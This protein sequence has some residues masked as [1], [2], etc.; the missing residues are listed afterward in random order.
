MGRPVF[1]RKMLS[2]IRSENGFTLMEVAAVV[3]ILGIIVAGVIAVIQP[4]S[5]AASLKT[6]KAN[7]SRAVDALAGYVHQY[8][9]LPCPADPDRNGATEPYGAERGSGAAGNSFGSC[10]GAAVEGIL[11]FRTLGLTEAEAKDGWG[12]FLTYRVS[13]AFTTS[14]NTGRAH[15][16]CRREAVWFDISGALVIGGGGGDV[17]FSNTGNINISL[18]GG[19]VSLRNRNAQ[20]ARFC[21]PDTAPFA[22]AT[23]IQILD[24]AGGT[25]LWP[26]VRSTSDYDDVN[27]V[28]EDPVFAPAADNVT[29]PAMVLV[30]HGRNGLGAFTEAGTRIPLAGASPDEIENANGDRVFVSR[31]YSEG[32]GDNYFDD[33][34]IWRTQ[35]HL[36]TEAGGGSCAIP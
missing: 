28:V 25:T 19:G 34:V 22:P 7:M 27:E 13:P 12:R 15:A 17:I 2:R 33:I 29:I 4:M 36:Y 3:A 26:F 24:G 16:R 30:S 9:R 10:S 31:P 5:R 20:K 8:N 32:D 14:P 35:D 1:L 6:T 18:G 11:P 21:C 23:D